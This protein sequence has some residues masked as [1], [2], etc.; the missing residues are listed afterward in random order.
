MYGIA[1]SCVLITSISMTSGLY[2]AAR[3]KPSS[4]SSTYKNYYSYLGVDGDYNGAVRSGHCMHTGYERT[5]WW[6]VNLL[7]QFEVQQIKLYN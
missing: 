5:P 2:N 3:F 4:Q 7:G 6:I 1:V